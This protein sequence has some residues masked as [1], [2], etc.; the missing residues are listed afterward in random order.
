[1]YHHHHR[2]HPQRAAHILC[3]CV[4]VHRRTRKEN[5][6]MCVVFRSLL[7]VHLLQCD[8]SLSRCTRSSFCSCVVEKVQNL[9]TDAINVTLHLPLL[10][11]FQ[12]LH[13]CWL[14]ASLTRRHL[15]CTKSL[16]LFFLL[17][18]VA[19]AASS[20]SSFL[21]FFFFLF[22]SIPRIEIFLFN[23]LHCTH[24]T[25]ASFVTRSIEK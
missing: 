7:R 4:H 5:A 16:S 15:K 20:S 2:H 13:V 8:S 22:S 6:Q 17:I 14:P 21:F 1:M 12:N 9:C 11:F 3:A 18:S 19:A 23:N 10:R 24:T 25:Y